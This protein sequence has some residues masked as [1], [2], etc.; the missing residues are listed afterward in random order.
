M[1]LILTRD[2][3]TDLSTTGVL[4]IN[5]EQQCYTLEDVCR[6][7]GIKVPGETAIPPGLYHVVDTWSPRFQRTLPLVLDVRGFSGVRI[8][9][10]NDSGDTEGCILVG[11]ER[12]ADWVANSRAAFDAL[13]ARL[14]AG[15]ASG[16]QVVLEVVNT[17]TV[18]AAIAAHATAQVA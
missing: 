17:P 12:R 11:T 2:T 9:P 13:Y 6:S 16:D 5:G 14:Q 15:W 1:E 3:M 8:H 7:D 4:T 18:L 10:G